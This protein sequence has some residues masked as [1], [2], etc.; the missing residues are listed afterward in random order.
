M[1]ALMGGVDAAFAAA[2][3]FAGVRRIVDVAG[4]DATLLIT[5]LRAHPRLEGVLF[6]RP[7]VAANARR[8]IAEAGLAERCATVAGDVFE[9]VPQG[10]DCYLLARV[11]HDW[12]DERAVAILHN[13]CRA[14][15]EGGRLLLL[16]RMFPALLEPSPAL[17]AAA[18]TDVNMMVVTGG[19]E[20]TEAEYR[21]LLSATGFGD[22]S[23]IP[24]G[25]GLSVLEARA[26]RPR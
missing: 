16:E 19:R 21:M 23:I 9:S 17:H 25:S 4:G 8:R 1:G 5:L 7:E 26:A 15:A 20:R 10:G 3:P 12:D 13:C 11:I 2:Y 14:L 18:L 24:T 22:M 6:D